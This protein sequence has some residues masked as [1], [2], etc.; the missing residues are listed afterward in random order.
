MNVGR[1]SV[2]SLIWTVKRY[3]ANGQ[4]LITMLK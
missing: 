4:S 2:R 3:L 1:Q